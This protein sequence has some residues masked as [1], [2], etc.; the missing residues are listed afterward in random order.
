M[1]LGLGD[2]ESLCARDGISR[3]VLKER[4]GLDS[5]WREG[6][7]FEAQ[8]TP[9]SKTPGTWVEWNHRVPDS[10]TGL[11]RSWELGCWGSYWSLRAGP[12]ELNR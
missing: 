2:E 8:G 9:E 7:H 11:G 3:R 4:K 5:W 6:G 10:N 1:A 12:S